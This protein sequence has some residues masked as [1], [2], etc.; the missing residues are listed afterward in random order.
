M[1]T[2]VGAGLLFFELYGIK[3]KIRQNILLFAEG[4][5]RYLKNSPY[6]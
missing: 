1:P 6:N 2:A 3:C 5:W 4:I